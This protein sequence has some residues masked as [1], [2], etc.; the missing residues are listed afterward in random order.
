MFQ[1]SDRIL[2]ILFVIRANAFSMYPIID[3][4]IDNQLEYLQLF[5]WNRWY[6]RYEFIQ[7]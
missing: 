4:S 3:I 6:F 2:T 5:F 1:L 7:R